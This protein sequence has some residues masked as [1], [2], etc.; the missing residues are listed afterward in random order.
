[1]TPPLLHLQGVT[2]RNSPRFELRIP[3]LAIGA[4][5]TVVLGPNGCGKTSLLRLLATVTAPSVGTLIVGGETVTDNNLAK[6]RRRLGYLPQD[7]SVP[8]RLSVFDHVDLVA[9]M[10]ELA[11]NQRERRGA[12]HRALHDVDLVALAGERCSRLSGGQRK[13]VALAAAL[14]GD[15]DLLV[16]DEPDA[17]LDDEQLARLSRTLQDRRSTTTIVVATHDRR[18]VSDIADRTIEMADGQLVA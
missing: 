13:R 9:V 15:A 4:G 10:R 11:P 2:H 6:V 12:V 7:D 8:R 5:V 16:L 14:A 3:S 17:H 18:W 1:M